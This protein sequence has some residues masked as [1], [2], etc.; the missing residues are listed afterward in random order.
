LKT[1]EK[2]GE[3]YERRRLKVMGWKTVECIR[4]AL[5]RVGSG[6]VIVNNRGAQVFQKYRSHFSGPG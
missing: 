6:L 4:L 2:M 5:D 1:Q 3:Y